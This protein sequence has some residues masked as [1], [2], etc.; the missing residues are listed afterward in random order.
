MRTNTAKYKFLINLDTFTLKTDKKTK[1]KSNDKSQLNSP[2]D[3]T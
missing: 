1:C 2:F 3:G